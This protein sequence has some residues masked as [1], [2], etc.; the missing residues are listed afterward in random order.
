MDD[1]KQLKVVTHLAQAK[2]KC[3]QAKGGTISFTKDTS[4]STAF[5]GSEELKNSWLVLMRGLYYIGEFYYVSQVNV[6]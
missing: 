5:Y 3:N 6:L 1:R 2:S 4:I